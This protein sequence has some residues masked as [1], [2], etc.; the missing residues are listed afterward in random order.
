MPVHLV[1]F[2][3]WNMGLF[4]FG[5]LECLDIFLLE[6]NMANALDSQTGMF[7]INRS[8]EANKS[9]KMNIKLIL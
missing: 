4:T 1:W 5:S 7:D 2:S 8:S 3:R 6:E 9:N